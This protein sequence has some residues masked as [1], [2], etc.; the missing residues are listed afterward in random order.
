MEV[1]LYF[2]RFEMLA[3]RLPTKK[4]LNQSLIF[5]CIIF[6]H[7]ENCTRSTVITRNDSFK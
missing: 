2:E 1:L 6:N 3:Y 7:N 4:K 5:L